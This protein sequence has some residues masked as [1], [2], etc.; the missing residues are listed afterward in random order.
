MS[1]CKSE[2]V[3]IKFHVKLK[4][5]MMETFQLLTEAYGEDCMSRVCMFERHKWFSEGRESLKDDDRPGCPCTA[6][7]DDNIEN[8]SDVI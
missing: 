8:V 5:S 1:D 6:V 7:T 2:W 3:N 4:K